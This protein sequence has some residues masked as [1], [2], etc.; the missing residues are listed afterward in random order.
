MRGHSPCRHA[1]GQHEQV[2]RAGEHFSGHQKAGGNP[3]GSEIG[4]GH[5]GLLF[6]E[7]GLQKEAQARF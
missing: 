7:N 5:D 3:P 6:D 2:K 1:N 4:Y